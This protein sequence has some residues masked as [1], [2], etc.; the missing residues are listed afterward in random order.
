VNDIPLQAKTNYYFT[1]SIHKLYGYSDENIASILP[2][3][4]NGILKLLGPLNKSDNC[5]FKTNLI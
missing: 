1:L 5:T 2:T 3:L 4:G